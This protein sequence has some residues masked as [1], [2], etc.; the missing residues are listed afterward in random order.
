MSLVYAATGSLVLPEVAAAIAAD[1][2]GARNL[3][4]FG[5]VFLVAGIAFKAGAAPFHM[6][7]P[8]VYTGAPTAVTLFISAAPK[9]AAFALAIRVLAEAGA[10]LA[11]DWSAMLAI[12]AVASMAIGNITAIA[13]QSMKRMLAYSAI[14][15]SGFML[16]GLVAATPQG[17]A[18]AL[19]YILSYALMTLGGFG[20]L[21]LLSRDGVD[22]DRLDDMRGMARRNGK[23][24][25]L[26]LVLMLSMAGVPPLVG[27]Y[28]KLAVWSAVVDAGWVWLAVIAAVLSVVGAFYYLRV[29]KLMY[30]DEPIAGAPPVALSAPQL[31][32]AG[33]NCLLVV[34]LGI[35]PGSLLLACQR[36]FDI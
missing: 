5:L 24:A 10:P 8:D 15:H 26:I 7:L 14:A 28:A 29:V 20:M 3:L 32:L 30:F 16:L 27:F 13:Q 19:F 21:V 25:A 11:D 17:Y 33:A 1:S 22:L 18:A 9:I 36:V 4:A 35:L 23:V 34:A 12:L 2:G 6:W 31:T